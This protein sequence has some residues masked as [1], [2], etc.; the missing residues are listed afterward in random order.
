MI[1]L[2][3][4]HIQV[5]FLSCKTYFLKLGMILENKVV[6]KLKLEK[7]FLFYKKWSPKL[8]FLNDFFF[9]K[10]PSIFDIEN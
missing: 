4:F 3:L 5:I 7:M 2:N 6:H 9:E 8:I 10:I 1:L